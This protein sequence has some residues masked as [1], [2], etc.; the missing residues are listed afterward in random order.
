[1]GYRDF[2]I[3]FS[4]YEDYI[5]YLKE[6]GFAIEIPK[7]MYKGETTMTKQELGS[8]I[9]KLCEDAERELNRKR[10]D[11]AKERKYMR[12]HNFDIENKALEYKEKLVLEG[13]LKV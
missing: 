2:P 9:H 5:K 4:S 11:V 8:K 10:T 12:E 1:M 3:E 13:Q 7:K 6:K